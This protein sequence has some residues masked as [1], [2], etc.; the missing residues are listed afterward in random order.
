MFL[1][2]ELVRVQAVCIL[3]MCWRTK[4]YVD[5]AVTGHTHSRKENA[6][7]LRRR[8]SLLHCIKNATNRHACKRF[9][10][11][12]FS[13]GVMNQIEENAQIRHQG[14]RPHICKSHLQN[15]VLC[16]YIPKQL[17]NRG[18]KKKEEDL[19]PQRQKGTYFLHSNRDEAL[20]DYI[21]RARWCFGW[22]KAR[23][24]QVSFARRFDR[25]IS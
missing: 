25:W 13:E 21:R 11:H 19:F 12:H 24:D 4:R 14:H 17:F 6:H 15:F 1:K 10:V 22:L 23:Q 8:A 20:F 7:I 2:C 9:Y 18:E 3:P 16:P 5:T